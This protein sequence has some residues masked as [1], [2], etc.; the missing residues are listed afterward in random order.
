[1]P[2]DYDSGCK[3]LFRAP[4]MMRDLLLGFLGHDWVRSD[5]FACPGRVNGSY[6]SDDLR[7]RHGDVVLKMRLCGE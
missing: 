5:D 3:R 7:A 6:V 1:M 2:N 4:E